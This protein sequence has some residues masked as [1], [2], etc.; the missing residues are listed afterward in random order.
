[1]QEE[2]Q[3]NTTTPTAGPSTGPQELY[4]LQRGDI[5]K[6]SNVLFDAFRDDPFFLYAFG[7]KHSDE[8]LV[9][10]MHRFTLRLGLRYG[11]V[12]APTA[13]LEGIVIWLSPGH[14]A[15][16]PWRA[17][18]TGILGFAITLLQN[19]MS[20][21]SFIERMAAFSSY[22]DQLHARHAHF[23]HWYLLA[24]GIADQFRGKGYAS[25]LL[26]PML[27]RCDDEKL[28]CYL[29]THNERNLTFY[30]HFGFV[31]REEG[32]IPGSNTRQWALLRMP[33]QSG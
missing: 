31:V 11:T 8:A 22:S 13:V 14:T 26:R 21:G 20:L 19:R 25:R 32:K 10:Q 15:I 29:E 12:A 24:I 30:Q 9:G 7:A 17:V 33:Y 18:R 5:K 27:A 6:A 2:R 16:T 28:P 1:M 4:F 23:P 3:T